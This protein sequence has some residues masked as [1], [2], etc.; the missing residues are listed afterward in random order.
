[1]WLFLFT[2]KNLIRLIIAISICFSLFSRASGTTIVQN[3]AVAINELNTGDFISPF[4]PGFLVSYDRDGPLNWG[5]REYIEHYFFYFNEHGNLM[6]TITDLSLESL[7]DQYIPGDFIEIYRDRY[8]NT[9]HLTRSKVGLNA[10]DS[11]NDIYIGF[12][13]GVGGVE[14]QI[15]EFNVFGWFQLRVFLEDPIQNSLYR[16]NN[17][18]PSRF[19]ELYPDAEFKLGL[20]ESV[21]AYDSLGIVIGTTDAIPAP[22]PN[23]AILLACAVTFFLSKRRG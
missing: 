21:I 19:E 1:M 10:Y 17:I 16:N 7:Y 6:S 13:T 11:R 22:E 12:A 18:S 20:I 2:M 3:T 4:T 8:F 23:S 9:Q 5:G 15:K 14:S